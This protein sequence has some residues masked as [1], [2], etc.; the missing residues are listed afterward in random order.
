MNFLDVVSASHLVCEE[1]TS[2]TGTTTPPVPHTATTPANSTATGPTPTPLVFPYPLAIPVGGVGA[3][4]MAHS[5]N[6]NASN[7]GLRRYGSDRG[8]AS[9]SSHSVNSSGGGD[10]SDARLHALFVRRVAELTHHQHVTRAKEDW[11]YANYRKLTG[12]NPPRR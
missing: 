5:T 2:T 11:A 7:A 4:M 10:V 8:G 12:L 6:S 3:L 1:Q 9:T